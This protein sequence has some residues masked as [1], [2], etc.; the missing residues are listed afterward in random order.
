MK[1]FDILTTLATNIISLCKLI[2]GGTPILALILKNQ[3]KDIKG[4]TLITPLMK[5]KFRVLKT[6]YII[7]APKN[8]LEDT[9]P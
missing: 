6:L 5:Y 7:K 9:K 1:P 4:K 8:I 2:V 3:I